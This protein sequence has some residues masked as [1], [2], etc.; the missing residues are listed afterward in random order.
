MFRLRI[1]LPNN[2]DINFPETEFNCPACTQYSKFYSVSPAICKTCLDE[3]PAL[4]EM[5]KLRHARVAFYRGVN[6][7]TNNVER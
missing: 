2:V 3:L 5:L 6:N 1:T 7:V 4:D